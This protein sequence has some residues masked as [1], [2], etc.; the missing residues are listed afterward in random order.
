MNPGVI[1]KTAL[2]PLVGDRVYANTFPQQNIAPTWPSIRFTVVGGEVFPDLCGSEVSETDDVRVQ[3]DV[4]ALEYDQMRTLV[5][6]VISAMGMITDPPARRSLP[7]TE[8]FDA[9]TKTHRAII[10]YSFHPSSSEESPS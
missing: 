6:Q 2:G 5:Q 10:E 1:I 4:V 7:T 9:G 3:L 8:T